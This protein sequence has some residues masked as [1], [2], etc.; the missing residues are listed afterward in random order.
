MDFKKNFNRWLT[1]KKARNNNPLID[2]SDPSFMT[3]M[4]RENLI[5]RLFQ[6]IR[7][8]KNAQKNNA[9]GC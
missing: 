7:S 9:K 6:Y 3:T 1:F 8:K 2:H 5:D 4:E